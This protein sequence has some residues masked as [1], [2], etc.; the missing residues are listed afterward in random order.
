MNWLITGGAGYIGSH[1]AE[2]FQQEGLNYYCYDNL[3]T[4]DPARI[5]DR[6]RLIV[7]DIHDEVKLERVINEMEVS[8]IIH[9][10]AKKSVEES[11]EK[12]ILYEKTNFEAT[13]R[14]LDICSRNG[15]SH[16]IFSSTAAVYGESKSGFVSEDAELHPI[17]TYGV[18]KMKA[19]SVLNSYVSRGLIQ[20]VSL[21]YFNVIGQASAALKDNSSDN[22]VPR[23]LTAARQ[24]LKPQIYGNDYPTSDR[25]CIRD[26]VDVRDIARLHL[27]LCRDFDGPKLP[28]AL[29]VGTGVGV[30]VLEVMQSI[31]SRMGLSLN[32]EVLPR[33]QGDPA[34]LV[35]EI[36]KLKEEIGF[37][38][39]F[40]F[41]SSIESLLH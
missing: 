31:Y 20:G 36:G 35:A 14:I 34:T 2:L 39:K 21:R 37:V 26:Y 17:S 12:P 9:L 30:S 38:T 32:P 7:G 28:P 33:R 4:G 22:L 16:L 1:I 24:H 8:G 10:A 15:V 6:E 25:T 18:T 27:R 40:D 19:E 23:V 13:E 29:N 41:E 5:S 3:S 11:R